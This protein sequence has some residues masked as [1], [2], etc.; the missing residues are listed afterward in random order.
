MSME[1]KPADCGFWVWV[2]GILHCL[3][4]TILPFLN[5][6]IMW[7]K[8]YFLKKEVWVRFEAFEHQIF[9]KIHSLNKNFTFDNIKQIHELFFNMMLKT[10]EWGDFIK[11][12]LRTTGFKICPGSRKKGHTRSLALLSPFRL[13]EVWHRVLLSVLWRSFPA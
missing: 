12:P 4:H 10:C 9:C 6:L 13:C 2:W 5:F 3:P 8:S 11:R 1:A 7:K